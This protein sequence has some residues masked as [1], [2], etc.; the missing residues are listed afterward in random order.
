ML[1]NHELRRD[2][3]V[4]FGPGFSLEA[5]LP[6]GGR[7]T[8][9]GFVPSVVAFPGTVAPLALPFALPFALPL[10]LPLPTGR[11]VVGEAGGADDSLGAEV[12]DRRVG[13]AFGGLS[14]L[15]ILN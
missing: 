5:L 1:E 3:G 7:D 6:S 11:P 14:V 12:E 2:G 8:G 4:P 10:P 15:R 13:I 9:I